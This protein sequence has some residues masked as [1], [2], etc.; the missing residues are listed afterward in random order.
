MVFFNDMVYIFTN[1]IKNDENI[2]HLICVMI[3]R[4]SQVWTC[5]PAIG[6]GPRRMP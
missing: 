6:T 1:Y 3:L 2:H 4:F 5:L